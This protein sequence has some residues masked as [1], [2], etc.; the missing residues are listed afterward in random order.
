MSH[1]V[2]AESAFRFLI[3]LPLKATAQC[4]Q[5]TDRH[6]LWTQPSCM[7]ASVTAEML[8]AFFKN[9]RKYFFGA[10]GSVLIGVADT[11]VGHMLLHLRSERKTHQVS[12]LRQYHVSH[13]HSL[14]VLVPIFPFTYGGVLLESAGPF[15]DTIR[16]ISNE[17]TKTALRPGEYVSPKNLEGSWYANRNLERLR[18]IG[19]IPAPSM[20]CPYCLRPCGSFSRNPWRFSFH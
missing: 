10:A 12:V 4:T 2:S 3:H 19:H 20:C 13:R 17:F 15:R 18:G 14:P 5:R 11:C 7:K 6:P 16:C 1:M 8:I 9:K